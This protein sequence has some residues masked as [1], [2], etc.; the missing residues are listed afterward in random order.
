MQIL[1]Y[2]LQVEGHQQHYKQ[3]LNVDQKWFK[4]HLVQTFNYAKHYLGIGPVQPY[5]YHQISINVLIK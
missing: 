2:Y 5:E 3:V 1:L 4:L